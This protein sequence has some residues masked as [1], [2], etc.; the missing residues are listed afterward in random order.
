[1]KC[2]GQLI[3]DKET[4]ANLFC[5]YL[6]EIKLRIS[7]QFKRSP[8]AST[9][10]PKFTADKF[11]L[12]QV[13]NG[14]IYKQLQTLKVSKA[15]TLDGVPS[16]LLKDSALT[17]NIFLTYIVNLSI[18]SQRIP[19]DW[20][21]AK[22][23]PL[24][25]EGARDNID[26]YRPI[27]ILAVM[28]KILERAVQQQL[29]DYL[30]LHNFFFRYQCGFCRKYLTQSD[31]IRRNMD[32]GQLTGAIFI[33]FRKAFDTIDHKILLDKLQLFGIYD[34]EHRWMTDY[35]TDRT[36]SVLV[37]GVLSCPQ[38][39]TFEI[40]SGPSAIFLVCHRFAK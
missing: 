35:L 15:T 3:T 40:Y 31:S 2:D 9:M 24:Y 1:M 12:G 23:I 16:R 30:E 29:V 37:G 17:I 21:H 26:I 32:A 7:N 6:S 34:G 33:D 39:A 28:S 22:V 5:K 25:K 38:H 19:H 14:F 27:S 4:I 18:T 10:C 36:Q 8:I 20:K 11:H 13:T